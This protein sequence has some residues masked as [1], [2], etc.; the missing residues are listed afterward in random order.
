MKYEEWFMKGWYEAGGLI[1]PSKAG[2]VIG[3]TGARM[4]QIWQERN[5]KLYQYEKDKPFLGWKD[6]LNYKAQRESK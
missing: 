3:L 6:F 4:T 5:L 2:K 1:S